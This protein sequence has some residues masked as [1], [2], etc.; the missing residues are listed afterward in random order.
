MNYGFRLF[1]VSGA[2][3]SP[4]DISEET[5]ELL[6]PGAAIRERLSALYPRIVWHRAEPDRMIF[7]TLDGD[8][9]W[10]EFILYEDPNRSL[11][12]N[13]SPTAVT[14]WLIPDIC[15]ALALVA[16]DTQAYT[17]I[18]MGAP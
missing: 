1:K 10:Y 13:T 14:R 17:L 18:G 12:I 7:G 3:R 15:Q 6:D 11:T 8:D 9:G 4:D 16:L 5:T 2:V